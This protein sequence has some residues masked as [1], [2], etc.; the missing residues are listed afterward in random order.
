MLWLKAFHVVAMVTW[1][2]GL[3]Y[4]PRLFVY[5]ADAGDWISVERFRVMERK[6][7]IIMT[8]GAIATVLLGIAMIWAAPGY[9]K[10]GWLHAKLALVFL[11]VAYHLLCLKFLRDFAHDR[12][13]RTA[14][15]FRAFN[16]VPTLLLVGIV[17]LA[18]AK[19]F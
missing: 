19:P 14:R 18:V 3:F 16:E 2:A 4:L 15:W 13:T 11:L 12:K 9:L 6:L 10:M 5:H 17:V 8:V 1:F 7:F